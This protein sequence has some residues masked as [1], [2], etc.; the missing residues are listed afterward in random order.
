MLK[1]IDSFKTHQVDWICSLRFSNVILE[2]KYN[3][4]DFNE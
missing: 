2:L 1:S 3:H 4:C